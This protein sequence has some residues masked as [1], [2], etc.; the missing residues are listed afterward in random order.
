[1]A[2]HRLRFL[3]KAKHDWLVKRIRRANSRPA[4]L[5]LPDRGCGERR[6]RVAGATLHAAT[7]P[8]LGLADALRDLRSVCG[9]VVCRQSAGLGRG[10]QS[11][12]QPRRRPDEPLAGFARRFHVALRRPA[13]FVAPAAAWAVVN[14]AILLLGM[15]LPDRRFADL[16]LA[17]DS[18]PIAGM[19][20]LLGFFLWL[21]ARQAVENDR[22]MDQGLPPREQEYAGKALVWP[23]LVYIEL[24]AMVLL[25]T[26]LLSGRFRPRRRWS[27]RPIRAS[28]PARPRPRGTSSACKSCWFSPTPGWSA[29]SRRAPPC[30]G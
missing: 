9:M 2:L 3:R 19:A 8:P 11:G 12:D 23:D 22:R 25:A 16:V 18:I 14:L 27:S 7:A 1:M 13:W 24:I 5:R 15:S 28:R 17:T 29:S 6:C 30:S 26:L 10:D 21:A 20:C 4:Q